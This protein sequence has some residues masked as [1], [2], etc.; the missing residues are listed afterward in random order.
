MVKTVNSVKD[1]VISVKN[2]F[3]F[4]SI[5]T[6]QTV[7]N[8]QKHSRSN[9]TIKNGLKKRVKFGQ[10]WLMKTV[11]NSKQRATTFN[12]GEYSQ[13]RSAMV[14][15]SIKNSKNVN[16]SKKNGE[17]WPKMV[18]NGQKRSKRVIKGQQSSKAV[19]NG[20]QQSTA[21]SNPQQRSLRS[22]TVLKRS[23]LVRNGQTLLKTGKNY[24]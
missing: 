5:K 3:F 17:Y 15:S 12:T 19:K 6:V 20:Q 14:K 22:K 10:N 23:K 4:K 1:M 13:K 8:G 9:N 21:V 18:K 2:D 7:N 16:N 11:K 24:Q